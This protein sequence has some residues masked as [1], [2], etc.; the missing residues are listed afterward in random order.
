MSSHLALT[1]FKRTTLTYALT[2]LKEVKPQMSMKRLWSDANKNPHMSER[3]C[4][5]AC[6]VRQKQKEQEACMHSSQVSSAVNSCKSQRR[7]ALTVSRHCAGE[8]AVQCLQGWLHGIPS[9]GTAFRNN[10]HLLLNQTCIR[11]R[12]E[13]LRLRA[14]SYKSVLSLGTD[15]IS[16]EQAVILAPLAYC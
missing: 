16:R 3:V 5:Q 15:R 13:A 10:V 4:E 2:L 9:P 12:F 8:Q 1:P 14:C 11:G 7:Q 6:K